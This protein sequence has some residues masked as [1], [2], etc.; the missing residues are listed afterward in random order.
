MAKID[1]L[2]KKLIAAGGS[3][4]HLK[5]GFKPRLRLHGNLVEIAEEAE[6][7]E[8]G[9]SGLCLGGDLLLSSY[10]YDLAFS[11]S[12]GGRIVVVSGLTKK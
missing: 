5:Q 12:G 3:D 9:L 2:F 4:L 11:N 7:T 1:A 8:K 6:L 10:S